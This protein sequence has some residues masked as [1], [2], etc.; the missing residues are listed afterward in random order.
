M[1]VLRS[2]GGRLQFEKESIREVIFGCKI[3]E[4]D[5]HMIVDLMKSSQYKDVVFKQAKMSKSSFSLDFEDVQV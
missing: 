5:K 2:F 4:G 3:K 1:R